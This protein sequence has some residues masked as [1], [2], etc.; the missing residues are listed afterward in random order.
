M[1][2]IQVGPEYRSLVPLELVMNDIV[3][4]W[5]NFFQNGP[6]MPLWKV[7]EQKIY[8]GILERIKH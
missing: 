5:N 2:R 3:R 1:L 4:D 7:Y 8:A 6:H